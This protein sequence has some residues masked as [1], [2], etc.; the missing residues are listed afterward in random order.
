MLKLARAAADSAG[1]SSVRAAAPA[2]EPLALP[3]APSDLG[4]VLQAVAV[5][6]GVSGAL[7]HAAATAGLPGAAGAA[8]AAGVVLTA[9][10]AGWSAL[11]LRSPRR[12]TYA[13]GAVM[14]AAMLA[15]TVLV[16]GA[17][18]AVTGPAQV[19]GLGAQFAFL[20]VCVVG[21]SAGGARVTRVATRTGLTVIA[22]TM[23]ALVGGVGH[24][25]AAGTGP[26]PTSTAFLCHLV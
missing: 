12:R 17:G 2:H 11:L 18:T 23:S 5:G 20:G 24:A 21:A 26:A 22:L 19:V 15:A 25:H 14:S 7:W 1:M 9:L 4:T 13:A 10:Q 16:L 8:I 3:S 6:L